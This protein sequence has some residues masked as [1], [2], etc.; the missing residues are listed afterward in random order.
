M[1]FTL[2]EKER[3]TQTHIKESRVLTYLLAM[4]LERG[5]EECEPLIILRGDTHALLQPHTEW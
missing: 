3:A 4:T 5:V 1:K 2:E